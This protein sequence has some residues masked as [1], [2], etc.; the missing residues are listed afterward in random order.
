MTDPDRRHLRERLRQLLHRASKR[1]RAVG[2]PEP[3]DPETGPQTTDE[4]VRDVL[5]AFAFEIEESGKVLAHVDLYT[6]A[7]L[8]LIEDARFVG[9]FEGSQAA[10]QMATDDCACRCHAHRRIACPRCL[11]TN[12]CPVHSEPEVTRGL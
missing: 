9:R 4:K 7:V 3:R 11:D 12:P 1:L 8:T 5:T 10:L 2:R 6:H